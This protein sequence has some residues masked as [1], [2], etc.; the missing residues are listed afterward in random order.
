MS[1]VVKV[2]PTVTSRTYHNHAHVR[3]AKGARVVVHV[4]HVV[5]MIIMHHTR[6]VIGHIHHLHAASYPLTL[7][8][9]KSFAKMLSDCGLIGAV[10]EL[11]R[12]SLDDDGQTTRRN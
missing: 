8:E 7:N 2:K 1:C 3:G 11:C 6:H 4:R 9:S 5:H 10:L 12:I